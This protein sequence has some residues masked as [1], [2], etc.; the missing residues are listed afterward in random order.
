MTR[1]PNL[2]PKQVVRALTRAGFVVDHQTGSHAILYS[3]G[4]G[5]R[6]VVPLHSGDLPRWL[7]KQIIKQA[8]MSEAEFQELL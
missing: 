5:L 8:G 1:L 3:E 4:T 6:T 2:R 7:L